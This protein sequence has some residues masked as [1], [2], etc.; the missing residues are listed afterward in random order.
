MLS[1]CFEAFSGKFIENFPFI[2]KSDY[3]RKKLRNAQK[4]CFSQQVWK[5]ANPEVNMVFFKQAFLFKAVKQDKYTQKLY[6][7]I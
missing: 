7:S 5:G 2:Q 1:C 3:I 6:F 4:V